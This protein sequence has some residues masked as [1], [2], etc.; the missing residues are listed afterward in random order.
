MLSHALA[1]EPRL[2][3]GRRCT[4]TEPHVPGLQGY[5]V[6]SVAVE[7]DA[8]P[9]DAELEEL[10]LLAHRVGRRLAAAALGDPE[11]YSVLYNAAR[12]RRKPWPHF[13]ILLAASTA[14][15]RRAFALLHMKHILRWLGRA[16]AVL[17]WS[18][19]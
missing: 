7:Q 13:H 15:K 3:S 16:R 18:P 5:Y 6:L 11:C 12:T 1:D 2:A 19:V 14:Q 10:T 9:C 8:A 17:R 4:V